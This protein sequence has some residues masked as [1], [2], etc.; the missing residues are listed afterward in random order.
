[1]KPF[2]PGRRILMGPGPSDVP[3]RVRKAMSIPLV[4]HLD[5]AF[6]GLMADVVKALRELFGTENEFT[7][8]VS[9]SGT[10]GMET[11]FANLLEPGDTAVIGVAGVFGAR[12]AE[13]ARRLS[14][15]VVV[16]EGEWGGIVDPA[17]M[18]EVIEAE[19]PKLAAVVHGE[20]STGVLQPIPE[21]SAAAREAGALFI[22]DCV[23]SL[24]GCPVLID[25]WGVD[26]AYSGTQ[27]C[28][29]CPPGLSPVTF[30]ERAVEVV[31]SR[32]TGVGTFNLDLLALAEYWVGG[33][34]YH[35]TAPVSLIFA[36][37]ESL[38]MVFEEGLEARFKRHRRVQEMLLAGLDRLLLTPAAD[39]DHRLPMLT[40]IRIPE[41]A[42]D[43]GVR[44]FLLTEHQIEIGFGLGPL[45]GRIWRVGTMGASATELHVAQ[46]LAAMGQALQ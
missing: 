18:A 34:A 26:A 11:C 24:G 39:A 37:W 32:K 23:T 25:E 15:K 9:A 29:S 46:F 4:S 44:D 3:E 33:G 22:L 10:A 36:L 43:A 28:L 6:R 5:P 45:A 7:F 8:P 21:I 13:M 16:V 41:G 17:R 2:E 35:H 38:R 20:T 40:S 30:S 27:K 12:M 1:M 42:D 14:A 19:Q 31:R